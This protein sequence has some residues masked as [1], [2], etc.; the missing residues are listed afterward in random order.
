M[1]HHGR[2]S[3]AY[4]RRPRPGRCVALA[5]VFAFALVGCGDDD[6]AVSGDGP[7][8]DP[9]AD[10]DGTELVLQV[11]RTG[12]L[13]PPGAEFSDVPMATLLGDGTMIVEGAQIAVYPAP[14]LP[15]LFQMTLSDDGMQQL[16]DAAEDAG[17]L[18]PAPEYGRPPIA[19]ATTTVITV[20]TGGEVVT[21]EIYALLEAPGLDQGGGLPGLTDGQRERR[22]AVGAF[23]GQIT[24]PE[25]ELVGAEDVSDA[26]PFEAERFVLRAAPVQP[27]DDPPD[28]DV[29][30]EVRDWPLA[31]ISL[32]DAAECLEVADE[33][34]RRLAPI[35]A[36]ANT[37]TRFREADVVYELDVRPLLPHEDGCDTVAS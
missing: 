29:V 5:V 24:T 18:S 13:R 6:D 7:T 14:L 1:G 23:V 26:T 31:A 2:M 16:L 30:P 12:G 15:P 3:T 10:P 35:L 37:L 4:H 21:H 34:G 25:Q 22:E 19:D 11:H 36:D 8:T 27:V 20:R 17:L 28:G 9:S 32:A 33:H